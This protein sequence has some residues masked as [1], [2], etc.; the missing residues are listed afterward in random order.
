[1][2]YRED[3]ESNAFATSIISSVVAFTVY[4]AFVGSAPV[5]GCTMDF[6]FTNAVELLACA[7]LGILCFP[8]S[9][10]YVRLYY[11]SERRFNKW[12]IPAWLKPAVGGAFISLLVF[13]YPEVSGGGFEFIDNLMAGLV[14][15]SLWGVMLLL[16]IVLAKIVATALTVGSGGSGGV[17]GPSLF[18][19]GVIG[20]M[21]AGICELAFP[22]VIRMPEMFILV[23]MASFFA[24]A[25]KAPI[26]GVVMV[27]EMT[28]SYS[29]LP[30]LLIAAVMHIAFSRN[31]TIY[32]SQ[33]LNKFASPAHRR[34]MDRELIQAYDKI[35]KE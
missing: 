5:I 33:V 17:F 24:G 22:G 28:G 1:M 21:F 2:L 23:G 20:A 18:I 26:A 27:C 10:L 14:P 13:A 6:P 7:L 11:E 30:G 34:D 35:A 4:I 29:L 25:A 15:H 8:F 19:G 31:W 9:Y 16:G 3:F 12:T 32:K